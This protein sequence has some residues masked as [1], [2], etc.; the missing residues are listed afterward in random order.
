MRR[1]AALI[2]VVSMLF[3]LPGSVFGQGAPSPGGQSDKRLPPPQEKS[4]TPKQEGE[5]EEPAESAA[6]KG[7]AMAVGKGISTKT[8]AGI[9]AAGAA[10]LVVGIGSADQGHGD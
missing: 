3:I 4:P 9:V 6:S 5:K 2:L 10:A 7:G 1:I 8:V